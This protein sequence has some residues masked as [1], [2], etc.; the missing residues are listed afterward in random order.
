MMEVAADRTESLYKAQAHKDAVQFLKR[1]GRE[2]GA[3]LTRYEAVFSERKLERFCKRDTL[4]KPLSGEARSEVA[5]LFLQSDAVVAL[6]DKGRP[7]YTTQD[8]LDME[9]EAFAM[10]QSLGEAGRPLDKTTIDQEADRLD[11]K[12][13]R[14]G[15]PA[16]PEWRAALSYMM[17]KR[18]IA[19]VYGSPG[20][21][22]STLIE[23]AWRLNRAQFGKKAKAYCIA[24]SREQAAALREKTGQPCMTVHKFL[25]KVKCGDIALKPE[26]IV[27]GDEIGML[28]SREIHA[29]LKAVHDAGP[30]GKRPRL[31]AAGD[32]KQI[33]P[34]EAGNLYR[35]FCEHL[36]A[37]ELT[38]IKR[39]RDVKDQLA[40]NAIRDGN[41]L[42]AVRHYEERGSLSFAENTAAAIEA[43]VEDFVAFT[44]ALVNRD[45]SA[46][47]VAADR[48]EA[49]AM[50]RTARRLLKQ[51]GRLG[52]TA[53]VRTEAG[54]REIAVDDRIVFNENFKARTASDGDRKS[55]K[56]KVYA[57]ATGT[58]E[59]IGRNSFVVRLDD[60]DGTLV[61]V[62]AQKA[63][64]LDHA[65][66]IGLRD[67][68]GMSGK[69]VFAVLTRRLEETGGLNKGI[70]TVAFS[71]H[72]ETLRM[73][74]DKSVWPDTDSL[75]A[76][77]A[78][79]PPKLN[80][81]DLPLMMKIAAAGR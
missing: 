81:M 13:A 72:K 76:A 26:T 57:G 35:Y 46:I 25:K 11:A 34:K 12:V 47:M 9:R 39:Q 69:A 8:M 71:R 74:V 65:Y 15:E 10:A 66:A 14:R 52:Q 4:L 44:G 54:N 45:K 55:G 63:P 31:I 24:P 67:G 22:K 27:L 18:E 5:R 79:A 53:V 51:A 49:E 2:F 28:G 64:G 43:T 73:R 30:P 6:N 3:A 41:P 29:L 42:P 23:S 58:V 80:A 61:K 20:V 21:G 36:P 59:K 17:G 7:A 19:L 60:K 32:F 70:A 40:T 37:V 78:H 77:M 56:A 75:A 62:P 38:R 48:T 16:N 68:Q 50:N 33:P 1:H